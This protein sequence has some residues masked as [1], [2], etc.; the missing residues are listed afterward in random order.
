[1]AAATREIE[2]LAVEPE[3][4]LTFAD[5]ILREILGSFARYDINRHENVS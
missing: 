1:L 5:F 2:I 4:S 3:K